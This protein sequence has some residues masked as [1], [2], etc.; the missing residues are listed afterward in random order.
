M[1]TL[2]NPDPSLWS[3][4]PKPANSNGL[5][6]QAAAPIAS[7]LASC[8]WCGQ[9]PAFPVQSLDGIWPVS[10]TPGPDQLMQQAICLGTYSDQTKIM[11]NAIM[12][13]RS[14]V[15]THATRPS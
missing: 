5:M 8:C 6:T 3:W 14:F 7:R 12:M 13:I 4:W 10:I 15:G 9:K 1:E 2:V 11:S